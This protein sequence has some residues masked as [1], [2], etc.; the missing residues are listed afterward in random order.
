[1]LTVTADAADAGASVE[2]MAL[3]HMGQEAFVADQRVRQEMW[4]E[5]EQESVQWPVDALT[6]S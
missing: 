1:V 5:W 3:R 4:K 6:D 2:P